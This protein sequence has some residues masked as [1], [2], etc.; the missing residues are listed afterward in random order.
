M[1]DNGHRGGQISRK[2]DQEVGGIGR[3]LQMGFVVA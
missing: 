2:S 3:R 1:A